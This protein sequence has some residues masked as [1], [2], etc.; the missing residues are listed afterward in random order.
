MAEKTTKELIQ[1]SVDATNANTAKIDAQTDAIFG[2]TLAINTQT[3]VLKSGFEGVLGSLENQSKHLG[4]INDNMRKVVSQIA[5]LR[6][7]IF[8]AVKDREALEAKSKIERAESL[9]ASEM[10]IEANQFIQDAIQL[11]PADFFVWYAQ[12]GFYIKV[13]G[14][15][16]AEFVTPE[17]AI[18]KSQE[19]LE[20]CVKLFPEGAKGTVSGFVLGRLFMHLSLIL[21][22]VKSLGRT[23]KI[24]NTHLE[25]SS[26]PL[27]FAE[28]SFDCFKLLADNNHIEHST[29][30]ARTTIQLVERNIE[31]AE[32]AQL[33]EYLLPLLKAKINGSDVLAS[34]IIAHSNGIIKKVK[35]FALSQLSID[36]EWPEPGLCQRK[37]GSIQKTSDTL[38]GILQRTADFIDNNYGFTDTFKE[39]RS[40]IKTVMTSF[41]VSDWEQNMSTKLGKPTDT[42]QKGLEA[43]Y[44]EIKIPNT[45]E[46]L[47]AM[48]IQK[49]FRNVL[50]GFFLLGFT[51]GI[52]YIFH[53]LYFYKIKFKPIEVP[54]QDRSYTYLN[55]LRTTISNW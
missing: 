20:S 39:H 43:Y 37:I 46:E 47:K 3:D 51:W 49:T 33:L 11:N 9:L 41:N 29:L 28:A 54:L 21:N 4:Q 7:D 1:D 8:S 22:D 48:G 24:L 10:Y 19:S 26:T 17:V 40:R 5:G 32:P 15:E 25:H 27:G 44:E 50:V 45:L 36:E 16:E 31:T 14:E 18:Q 38:K 12:L 53:F 30:L 2:Q 34:K 42:F 52:G 35:D 6:Q 55:E 23:V 13:V